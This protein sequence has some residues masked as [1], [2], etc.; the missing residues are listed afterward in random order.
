M[1]VIFIYKNVQ[2]KAKLMISLL[3]A[4]NQKTQ[5][6]IKTQKLKMNKVENERPNLN[7]LLT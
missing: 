7:H 4:G 5:M 6:D 1:F 3:P 2:L